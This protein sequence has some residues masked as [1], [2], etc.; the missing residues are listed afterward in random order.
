MSDERCTLEQAT[1][2]ERLVR[3]RVITDAERKPILHHLTHGTMTKR[4]ASDQ[5]EGLLRAIK[6]RKANERK[7]PQC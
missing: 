3:S 2:I 1:L 7:A 6:E 5:I 4:R